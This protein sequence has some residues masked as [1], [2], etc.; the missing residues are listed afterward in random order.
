M[1]ELGD[2]FVFSLGCRM[3]NA[4]P[5]LFGMGVVGMFLF[6]VF[7]F[8]F[9]FWDGGKEC[10]LFLPL[11][12]LFVSRLRRR[13]R[14]RPLPASRTTLW[15]HGCLARCWTAYR[16]QHDMVIAP[17]GRAR[18]PPSDLPGRAQD[19]GAAHRVFWTRS[20]PH[21]SALCG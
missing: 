4:M 15:R 8:C 13:R 18:A 17:G 6:F 19:G 12:L 10:M 21:A 9:L 3:E 11:V 7:V 16:H 1:G 14:R 2:F 5:T 20:C